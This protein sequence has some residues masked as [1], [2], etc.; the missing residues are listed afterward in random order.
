V[1]FADLHITYALLGV[2][3]LIRVGLALVQCV[4]HL[5]LQATSAEDAM[6]H[7]LHPPLASLPSTVDIFI[8][9]ALSMKLKDDDVRKQRIKMESQLKRRIQTRTISTNGS[10]G[11]QTT[12]ISLPK[13][14]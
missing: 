10:S 7:L 12:S 2:T 13:A 9:Q 5:L 4:R 11:M 14:P 1:P 3:L 8:H 6:E